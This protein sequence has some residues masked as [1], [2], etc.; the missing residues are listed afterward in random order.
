[1]S[2][3]TWILVGMLA[4][5]AGA[6]AGRHFWLVPPNRQARLNL[7][8]DDLVEAVKQNPGIWRM[9]VERLVPRNSADVREA[10]EILLQEKPARIKAVKDGRGVRLYPAV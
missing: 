4:A 3:W 8:C 6:A 7:V 2:D 1:M 9:K 5:A 10:L